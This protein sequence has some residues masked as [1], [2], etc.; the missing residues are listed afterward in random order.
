M[1]SLF[2]LPMPRSPFLVQRAPPLALSFR[3][4][5]PNLFVSIFLSAFNFLFLSSPLAHPF[6]FPDS[7]SLLLPRSLVSSP[8]H[9]A[10]H[11]FSLLYF[12]LTFHTCVHFRPS[13]GSYSLEVINIVKS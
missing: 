11:L 13:I 7:A 4:D 9:T 3:L 2:S 10:F 6:V 8:L 12:P 1:S 5:F